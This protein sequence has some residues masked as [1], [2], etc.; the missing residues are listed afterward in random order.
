MAIIKTIKSK[1]LK[2][3][4]Y[5]VTKTKAIY[6]D[7]GTRLD[8]IMNNVIELDEIEDDEDSSDV[9]RDADTLGGLYTA[10]DIT[11]MKKEI[12]NLKNI[13]VTQSNTLSLNDDGTMRLEYKED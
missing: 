11:A 2:K 8:I 1:I 13:I 6:D 5:P 10:E 3:T 9:K 4:I 12:E 7:N